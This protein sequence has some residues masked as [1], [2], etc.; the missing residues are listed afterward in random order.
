MYFVANQKVIMRIVI[1]V[2]RTGSDR[3]RSKGENFATTFVEE[4]IM[5][6]SGMGNCAVIGIPFVDSTEY[7][8]RIYVLEVHNPCNLD[9]DGF[10]AFCRI[11]IPGYAQPG[12]IRLIRELPRT[13]TH[14]IIKT[15]LMY[16][17]IERTSERDDDSNDLIYRIDAD[18]LKEFKTADYRNEM[19]RCTDPAVR[20][21]FAIATRRQNLFSDGGEAK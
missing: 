19:A 8:N 17:F 10:I 2:G 18:G 5:Q 4:V 11:E 1:F 6:Y 3:L 14:K 15:R 16:D 20:A 9:L 7:N 13:A 21:W 12:F